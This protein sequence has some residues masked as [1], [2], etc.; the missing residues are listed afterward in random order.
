MNRR[1][2]EEAARSELN[3]SA[4][5]GLVETIWTSADFDSYIIDAE[6]Q[7]ARRLLLI[8]DSSSSFLA[9]TVTAGTL[10]YDLDPKILKIKRAYLETADR[11]LTPTCLDI[12][13]SKDNKWDTRQGTPSAYLEDYESGKIALDRIPAADDTLKLIVN[14]LPIV[15]V[16]SDT[17]DRDE[18]TPEIQAPYHRYMTNYIL[19]RA[20]KKRGVPKDIAAKAGDYLTLFEK[21]DMGEAQRIQNERRG[22]S[23]QSLPYGPMVGYP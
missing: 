1:D 14:R 7:L 9:V 11:V 3:D 15:P 4:G 5:S 13:L 8:T 12:M 22:I 16:P 2:F 18:I 10:A 21:L 19:Y 6:E 23:P 20:C 17:V